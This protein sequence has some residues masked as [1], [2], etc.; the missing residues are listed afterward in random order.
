MAGRFACQMLRCS[1]YSR[2]APLPRRRS[3]VTVN[4][5][6]CSRLGASALAWKPSLRDKVRLSK[7]RFCG[8]QYRSV[9]DDRLLV[10]SFGNCGQYQILFRSDSSNA[11]A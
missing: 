8:P 4:S 10:R 9:R 2:R 1:S 7:S 6:G 11:S 3:G 5:S